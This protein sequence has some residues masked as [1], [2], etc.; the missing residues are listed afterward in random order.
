MFDDVPSVDVS[1]ATLEQGIATAELVVS[2]G[3]SASKGE[4]VRLIKQGGLYVNDRRVTDERGTLTLRSRDRRAGD[5]AAE[6]AARAPAG[7]NTRVR[8]DI[9]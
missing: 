7:E 5:R 6:R 3:L 1:R 2:A 8:V 9:A 4:A